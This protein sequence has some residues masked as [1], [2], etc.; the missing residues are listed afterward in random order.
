MRQQHKAGDKGFVDYAG[1]T[2]PVHDQKTGEVTQHPI[3]VYA[4]GAS[5]FTYA[6][7]QECANMEAWIG[8]HIR[9]FEFLGGVPSA[10]V[11]DNLKVGVIFETGEL[12]AS[13]VSERPGHGRARWRISQ[14]AL[15]A[16]LEGRRPTPKAKATRRVKS[17]RSVDWV[18]YV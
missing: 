14:S 3:F 8:G 4:L 11:P 16:F 18:E 5:N 10:T 12:I 7:A 2:I 15:D 1:M 17:K 13:D 9:T 6:E